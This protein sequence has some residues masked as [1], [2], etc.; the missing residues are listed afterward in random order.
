MDQN[1]F[2][3]TI[4]GKIL[5]LSLYLFKINDSH[6]A[7]LK[8]MTDDLETSQIT[9]DKVTKLLEINGDEA[10]FEGME[11]EIQFAKDTIHNFKMMKDDFFLE[12]EE[13]DFILNQIK[14][15]EK[16][17]NMCLPE[18]KEKTE[19]ELHIKLDFLMAKVMSREYERI[20][21]F[22]V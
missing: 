6:I 2:T 16:S 5:L 21:K 10:T 15:L 20:K 11:E 18:L 8:S 22:R 7:K 4:E 9:I 12:N 17:Y 14:M 13:I 1:I 19:N 3:E